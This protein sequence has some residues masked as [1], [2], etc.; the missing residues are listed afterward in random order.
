MFVIPAID[1]LGGKVVR[2]HQGDYGQSTEYGLDPVAVATQFVQEGAT[3]VHVV[4]LDGARG[5]EMVHAEVVRDLCA[6]PGIQLEFGGGVRNL[7]VAEKLLGLGVGRVV[8]GTA[9]ARDPELAATAFRALGDRAVAG[10]DAR[11][12]EVATAG[13]RE[14][15]GRRATEFWAELVGYGATRAIVTDIARDGA[16]VGPNLE[17][18]A[19]MM[20]VS[21]GKVIASGGVAEVSD[22]GLLAGM[23]PTAPEAV[24]VGKAIYEG[25]FSVA[26]AVRALAGPVNAR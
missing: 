5:G 13:W 1:L 2:L 16:L 26:D 12:G 15:S 14:G 4:D 8:F 23:K 22:L 3:W 20:A 7:A 17:F 25:R 21:G 24:I 19:D 10:I 18:L 6:V 9:L 11:D